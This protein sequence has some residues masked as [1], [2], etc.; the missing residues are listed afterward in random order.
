MTSTIV[1][2]PGKSTMC[3]N[4]NNTHVEHGDEFVATSASYAI[5][6]AIFLIAMDIPKIF[7]WKENGKRLT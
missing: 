6:R 3:E 7:F 5:L 2:H 1:E 4:K